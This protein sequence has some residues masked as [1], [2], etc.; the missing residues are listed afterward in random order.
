MLTRYVPVRPRMSAMH[1]GATCMCLSQSWNPMWSVGTILTGLLSF[2]YDTQVRGVQVD[3]QIMQCDR[4]NSRKG[5]YGVPPPPKPTPIPSVATQAT[6]GSITTSKQDKERFARDS[7]AFNVKNA[8]FKKLFP[9]WVEEHE[10]RVASAAQPSVPETTSPTAPSPKQTASTGAQQADPVDEQKAD[11]ERQQGAEANAQAPG[12]NT[13]PEKGGAVAGPGPA[14]PAA[15]L[16]GATKVVALA[17]VVAVLAV[18]LASNAAGPG[19]L[20]SALAR[21]VTR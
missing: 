19:A 20:W 18:V 21:G 9:N 5:S 16:G 3:Y 10:R 6:T 2:M 12:A 1:S 14:P 17:V 7:L 11:G 8:T 4:L 13:A 15:V